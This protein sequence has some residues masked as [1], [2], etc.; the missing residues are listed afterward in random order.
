MFG[1]WCLLFSTRDKNIPTSNRDKAI[2]TWVRPVLLVQFILQPVHAIFHL[3]QPCSDH[4]T[5]GSGHFGVGS[6]L[7]RPFHFQFSPVQALLQPVQVGFLWNIY[8]GSA[9]V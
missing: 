7:F 4:S 2:S 3:V 6:A 5:S 9:L 8:F 1:Y